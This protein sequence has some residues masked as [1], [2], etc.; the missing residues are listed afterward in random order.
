MAHGECEV[1][2]RY[3]IIVT[4][5]AF[6]P[7]CWWRKW[8]TAND[9]RASLQIHIH[10]IASFCKFHCCCMM[11]QNWRPSS[12]LS[13]PPALSLFACAQYTNV[14]STSTYTHTFACRSTWQAPESMK[15]VQ[16]ASASLLQ[17]SIHRRISDSNEMLSTSCYYN[18]HFAKYHSVFLLLLLL[19]L[20]QHFMHPK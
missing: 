16:A 2:R 13:L 18:D 12:M 4:N 20:L 17:F 11:Q 8:R 15:T 6:Y 19:L 10:G 9:S 5:N 14:H 1:R 3:T 7:T